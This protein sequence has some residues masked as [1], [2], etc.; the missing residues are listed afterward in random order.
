MLVQ[1]FYDNV[2]DGPQRRLQSQKIISQTIS[3]RDEY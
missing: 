1:M 3:F 2:S